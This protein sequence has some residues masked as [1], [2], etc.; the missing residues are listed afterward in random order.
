MT[1]QS[2]GAGSTTR[3]RALFGLLSADGWTWASLKA[4]FWF[5]LII[6]LLGY[7]PDRAYYF[8]VFSTIDLGLN[9]I[10]PINLC[11]P[12]NRG[13]P[14]PAPAGAVLP[15]DPSPQD[16]ALP[17]GRFDGAA[18]QAGNK[19]LYIGGTDGKTASDQVYEA[20]AFA[21]GTFGKWSIGPALP[22]PRDKEAAVFLGGSIYVFGGLDASGKPTTTAYVLTPD[23]T[24]GALGTWKT[25]T[26]ASLPIDLP[27]ARAG[28]SIIAAPDGLILLG[29]VGADLKPT[30]TVWKS[31]LDTSGK[32]QAWQ[33][34]LAMPQARTDAITAFNG[35]Y[36]YV[37]GGSDA[38][39]ATS[40]VLRGAVVAA[41]APVS[42]AGVTGVAGPAL[43]TQWATGVGGTNLP[44][45]R[46]DAAGFLAN[47]G[48]YLV[49]GTDGKTSAGD[50]YWAVPDA[51]GDIGQWMHLSQ[52]DL[53]ASGLV[54]GRAIVNGADA[55]IIG[56]QN[57]GAAVAGTVRAGLAPQP[58]FFQLGLVG[59]TIP[60]LQIGGDVGQQLGY[61]AAASVGAGNFIL[62]IIIGWAYAHPQKVRAMRD[63]LR[64]RRRGGG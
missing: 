4:V 20:D 43:V 37:Y 1:E 24:T 34:T 41:A 39:G 61:I 25:S 30:T 31:T 56:G 15:W 55:F 52:S 36:M 57:N 7:I 11:P 59:A 63:K 13:L 32:L 47:G 62:L 40:V 45:A 44:V 27:A 53:P 6:M 28:S 9:A 51:N 17:A 35:Q 38:S 14:C 23:T 10:S 33:P 18:V 21:P 3:R 54:G 26:D 29:G 22:A 2:L 64:Q 46:T 19:F 16:L 5:I 60:A 58:P 42:P 49:A 48:L 50:L 8:T 12:Q